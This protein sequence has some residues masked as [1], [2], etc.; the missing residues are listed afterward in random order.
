MTAFTCRSDTLSKLRPYHRFL[1]QSKGKTHRQKSK[2]STYIEK[3]SAVAGKVQEK[4]EPYLPQVAKDGLQYGIKTASPIVSGTV[5]Y[6]QKTVSS[7][8]EYTQKTIHDTVDYGKKTINGTV[9][10]TQKTINNTVDYGKK[11][12]NGTVDYGK[13]TINGTVDYGKK[14]V[15]DAKSYATKQTTQAFEFGQVVVSGATT[16]ITAHTPGPILSLIQ[17]TVEGASALAKNP[18]GTVKPYIPTFIIHFGTKTYEIV[19]AAQEQG[20]EGIKA[21]SGF[22]VTKVDGITQS[23][24][25]VPLVA[26]IIEK[27]NSVTAPIISSFTKKQSQDVDASDSDVA[28]PA[29][30]SVVVDAEE[31]VPSA[32]AAL[33]AEE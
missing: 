19:G 9:E 1:V 18:I 26:Q 30:S 14:V 3:A 17:T 6:A 23:V 11:T 29:P 8:V 28:V 22:I 31:E 13:K 12:I 32:A 27:L 20:M 2:M 4:V 16:T 25:S 5:E 15:S 7:G 33:A 24:T 10:Y 21:A